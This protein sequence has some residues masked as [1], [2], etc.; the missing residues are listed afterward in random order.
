MQEK[1]SDIFEL[2]NGN[3]NHKMNSLLSE[4][5]K[6][7]FM[8]SSLQNEHLSRLNDYDS[9]ILS[10]GAYKN[11]SDEAFKLEYKI[12]RAEKEIRAIESQ[13]HTAQEIGDYIGISELQNE[14]LAKKDKYHS[15]LET[16]NET[17]LSA[18]ISDSFSNIM[19]KIYGKEINGIKSK[20]KLAGEMFIS[21][22]PVKMS[23]LFKIK[24]SLTILENINKNVDNLV[25]MSVP[26]GENRNKYN[27]L[28]NYII[29]ANSI[30]SKIS[31]FLKK[32]G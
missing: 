3:N 16:Y 19:R 25:T 27:Q 5:D 4:N 2:N 6:N 20:I 26:Y 17:A 9:N 11:M 8:N 24:K 13:I 14:L 23:S 31:D 7:P 15:L 12:S 10:A 30:Q 21:K 29:K 1:D 18:K 22:M 28:S 32:N